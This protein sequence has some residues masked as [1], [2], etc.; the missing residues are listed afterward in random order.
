MSTAKSR[1]PMT[2]DRSQP[3]SIAATSPS[4]LPQGRPL[5]RQPATD[6][7]DGDRSRPVSPA[8]NRYRSS[9]RSATVTCFTDPIA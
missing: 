1:A 4:R 7:T 5:I 8:A 6:G 2:V 9:D 3:A